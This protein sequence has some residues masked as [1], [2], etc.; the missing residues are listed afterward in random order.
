MPRTGIQARA[1]PCRAPG[2]ACSGPYRKTAQ[3]GPPRDAR[4]TGP[5]TQSFCSGGACHQEALADR[6]LPGSPGLPSRKPSR[7]FR[8]PCHC[9]PRGPRQERW[10]HTSSRR[11][12]SRTAVTE[13]WPHRHL[14]SHSGR[15]AQ[16]RGL[17]AEGPAQQRLSSGGDSSAGWNSSVHSCKRRQ[18]LLCDL[19]W[20]RTQHPPASAS[21]G[22]DDR[23]VHCDCSCGQQMAGSH[24]GPAQGLR[25]GPHVSWWEQPPKLHLRPKPPKAA[26]SVSSASQGAWL[27]RGPLGPPCWCGSHSADP[28]LWGFP[29][30]SPVSVA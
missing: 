5:H 6:F 8:R 12:A 24:P 22:W 11:P 15:V 27:C 16:V 1:E 3:P 14:Y 7:D 21:Q 28:L 10:R 25:A 20:P 9:Q 23:H 2:L 29:I 18:G 13:A 19:G 17:G 26:A 4:D 30:L